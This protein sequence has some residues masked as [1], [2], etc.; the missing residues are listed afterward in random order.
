MKI[1]RASRLFGRNFYAG[2]AVMVSVG[3]ILRIFGEFDQT[4]ML[5]MCI[6]AAVFAGIGFLTLFPYYR[7]RRILRRF[8]MPIQKKLEPR[9]VIPVRW[10]RVGGKVTIRFQGTD[11]D[12]NVY[13]GPMYCISR[14]DF[15][16][17]SLKRVRMTAYQT[18]EGN[19]PCI[20]RCEVR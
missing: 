16:A 10:F 8:E 1:E 7:E 20:L 9:A 5:G 12:G 2:A 6:A 18:G 17:L 11:E 3:I 19:S 15:R 13:T 14:G 4:E